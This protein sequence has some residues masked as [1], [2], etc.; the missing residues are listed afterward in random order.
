MALIK[1]EKFY[2][3]RNYRRNVMSLAAIA[4]GLMA[5]ACGKD[6]AAGQQVE[7]RRELPSAEEVAAG[8]D[9]LTI[10][11]KYISFNS[12]D[13]GTVVDEA[14]ARNVVDKMSH[15]WRQC[16]IQFALEQYQTISPSDIGARYNPANYSE[17]DEMRIAAHSDM[18][19]IM[20]ATGSWNRSGSLGNSGS[21]CYSS[22]P[23]DAAEG[24]VCEQKS[25][26]KEAMMAHEAGHWVNLRHTNSPGTDGVDDTNS[27]NVSNN[28]MD[29][30]VATY[31]DDLTAGQCYRA[32]EAIGRSRRA[33]VMM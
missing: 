32:R 8:S 31:H 24:I 15:Y 26:A 27:G 20:I 25:A 28:L 9:M 18:H 5:T 3:E 13:G 30:V 23:G 22:F 1:E 11:V 16:N 7:G 29:H 4:L 33:T 17:L 21:N 10:A 19:L 2:M 14:A 12:A 6:Y